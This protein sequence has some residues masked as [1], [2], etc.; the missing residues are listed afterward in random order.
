LQEL[1]QPP[2]EPVEKAQPKMSVAELTV[3]ESEQKQQ[4]LL[5]FSAQILMTIDKTVPL[6][7]K[8]LADAEDE[9]YASQP[10]PKIG[11][12]LFPSFNILIPQFV[13]QVIPN[14]M[15]LNSKEIDVT[16]GTIYDMVM[17]A[18]NT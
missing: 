6:Y 9:S 4:P 10:V 7:M 17:F 18:F 13:E 8:Q 2:A 1:K 15:Q 16:V 12:L 14:L 11:E 3:I 5:K